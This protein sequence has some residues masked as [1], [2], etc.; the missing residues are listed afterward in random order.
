MG[1]NL[2]LT[3]LEAAGHRCV[4]SLDEGVLTFGVDVD[5]EGPFDPGSLLTLDIVIGPIP[6]F[7]IDGELNEMLA[8][9][10][11]DGEVEVR[12]LFHAGDDLN[13]TIESVEHHQ[14]IFLSPTLATPGHPGTVGLDREGLQLIVTLKIVLNERRST[15]E[16]E[17][18]TAPIIVVRLRLI[19]AGGFI[20]ASWNEVV[21]GTEVR[22]VQQDIGQIQP[23]RCGIAVHEGDRPCPEA[24]QVEF[25]QVECDDVIPWRGGFPFLRPF[26]PCRFCP[27]T[28]VVSAPLHTVAIG[29]AQHDEQIRKPLSIVLFSGPD[30]VEGDLVQGPDPPEFKGL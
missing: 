11:A 19:V 3:R 18:R 10:G 25:G 4:Q 22:H 23:G 15:G 9:R 20:R 14:G 24:G 2:I 29:V 27:E 6:R 16:A 8:F 12:V 13:G 1:Q 30:D 17:V 26:Q 7:D 28:E 5:L 21:E